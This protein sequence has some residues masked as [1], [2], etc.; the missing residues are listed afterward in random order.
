MTQVGILIGGVA[1]PLV[2]GTVAAASSYQTA[3]G[4]SAAMMGT[5]AI[6]VYLTA[7]DPTPREAPILQ[8]APSGPA[9][10]G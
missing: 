10:P 9:G 7:Q 5:A 4:I 8:V 2:A 6:L 1:G 3:W